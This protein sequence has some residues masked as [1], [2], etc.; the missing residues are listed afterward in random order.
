MTNESIS[1]ESLGEDALLS[2]AKELAVKAQTPQVM[3]VDP[4]TVI[5]ILKMLVDIIT[6]LQ[7]R[8]GRFAQ[9]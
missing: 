9:G 5:T 6:E 1:L 4:V 7:K 2:M 8:K 3:S